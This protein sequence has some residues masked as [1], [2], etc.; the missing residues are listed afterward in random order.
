[1]SNIQV[2]RDQVEE[3]LA[4]IAFCRQYAKQYKDRLEELMQ[5][6][7]NI[8]GEHDVI[9]DEDAVQVATWKYAADSEYFDKE[10]F[11]KANPSVYELFTKMR[12]GSR[13]LVIK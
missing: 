10:E 9:V 1:M 13:R 4:D 12:P 3:L 6:L 11:K 8:V 7:Y 2:K 5:K